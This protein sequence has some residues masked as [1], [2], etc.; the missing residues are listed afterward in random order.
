MKLIRIFEFDFKIV[1]I[2]LDIKYFCTNI[3]FNI[4]LI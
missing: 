4:S 3:F 1:D 2:F